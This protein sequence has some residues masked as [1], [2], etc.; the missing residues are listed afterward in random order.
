MIGFMF[1]VMNHAPW[2][3]WIVLP[4]VD[5]KI[6]YI[7]GTIVGSVTTALIAIALKKP[8]M[9]TISMLAILKVMVLLWVRGKQTF[10]P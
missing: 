10:W 6:G 5:G 4:V 1:H 8:S 9:K 7:V 3:G 2:G